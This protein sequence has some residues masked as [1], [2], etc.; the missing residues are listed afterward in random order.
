MAVALR[1]PPKP[2][3]LVSVRSRRWVVGDVNKSKL[4]PPPLEP[5]ADGPQHLVSLL[6]VEDN[7]LGEELQVIWETEPGAQ[8]VE[9]ADLPEPSGFDSPTDS[10]PS[11][12][13]SAGA[14]PPRPT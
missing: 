11:S 4:P 5:T 13:P 7:A 3:Q 12:M 10:T 6:S 2:G 8:V 14:L 9:R 1:T